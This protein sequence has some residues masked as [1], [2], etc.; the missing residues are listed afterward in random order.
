MNMREHSSSKT[1]LKHI[2]IADAVLTLAFT[3]TISGGILNIGRNFNI[4]IFDLPIVALGV[5]LSFI[6]HEMMHKFIAQRY[7]AI[8]GFRTSQYGLIITIFSGLMG[9]LL[10][11]PGATMIYANNFSKKENGIVSFAGPAVNIVIFGIAFVLLSTLN[12]N[13]HSYIY[14]ALD[15][16]I[17]INVFLAFFNMLP[18]PPLDGSK[19]LAWNIPIYVISMGAILILT[20]IFTGISLFNIIFLIIIALMF[21]SVYRTIL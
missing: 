18:I 1:E 13:V 20:V 6:L 12:L 7:G 8:A 9:F 10:G 11:I 16:L 19:V 3:F 5:T 14:Q 21:S 2:L 4:F 15:F 17:Y